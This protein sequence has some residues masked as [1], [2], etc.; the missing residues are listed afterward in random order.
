MATSLALTKRLLRTKQAAAY[1]AISE[2]KPRIL[3]QDGSVPFIQYRDG[4]PFLLDLLDLDAYIEKR[5]HKATDEVPAQR[6]ALEVFSV[7][8]PDRVRRKVK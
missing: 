6:R 4:G 5:K 8:A 7:H 3:I 1:L 2:W